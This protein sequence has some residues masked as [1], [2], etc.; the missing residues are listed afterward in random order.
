MGSFS[1]KIATAVLCQVTPLI[2]ADLRP[3]SYSI[4]LLSS[5]CSNYCPK[6]SDIPMYNFFFQ[7]YRLGMYAPRYVWMITGDYEPFWWRRG[8]L[9]NRGDVTCTSAEMEQSVNGSFSVGTRAD[10]YSTSAP[11]QGIT[12]SFIATRFGAIAKVVDA[13]GSWERLERNTHLSM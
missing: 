5:W 1:E 6:A 12:V 8:S 13:W 10:I 9:S 7:A 4:N 3:R 2:G 11:P